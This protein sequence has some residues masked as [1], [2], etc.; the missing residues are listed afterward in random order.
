LLGKQKID[1]FEKKVEFIAEKNS[2]IHGLAGWFI[3][4]LANGIYLSTS[5]REPVL[6]WK[7]CF[8]PIEPVFVKRGYNMDT[9]IKTKYF[10][11]ELVL[12]WRVSIPKIKYISRHTTRY[13]NNYIKDKVK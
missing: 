3:A 10:N 8:F 4:K 9:E 13:F 6:H 1:F 12:S 7:H 2:Y 5:P 11:K